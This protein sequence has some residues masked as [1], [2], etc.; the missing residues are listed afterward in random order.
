MRV[1][2]HILKNRNNQYADELDMSL[3]R[4]DAPNLSQSDAEFV[5]SVDNNT[6]TIIVENRKQ[7]FS[8]TQGY[9]EI[10]YVVSEST[11]DYV[12]RQTMSQFDASVVIT[13]DNVEYTAQD[14]ANPVAIDTDASITYLKKSC[15]CKDNHYTSWNSS[16]GAEPADADR[17][18]YLVW[19]IR[20]EISATQPYDFALTDVF[21]YPDASIVGYKL[22]GESVYSQNRTL[23]NQRKTGYRTDY[24]LTRHKKSSYDPLDYYT[25]ENKVKATVTPVDS[26]NA[27]YKT[28]SD[29]YTYRH[30]EYHFPTG[31]LYS[32]KFGNN[33]WYEY[34][35]K[36]WDI[37]SYKLNEFQRYDP[38]IYSN[39]ELEDSLYYAVT[40]YGYQYPWTLRR[41]GDRSDPNDL[42]VEKVSY[43]IEDYKLYLN[44]TIGYDGEIINADSWANARQLTPDDYYLHN[45]N[46]WLTVRDV[47]FNNVTNSF[48]NADYTAYTA[49]DVLIFEGRYGDEWVQLAH[50]SY[51]TSI[52]S[53]TVLAPDLVEYSNGRFYMKTKTCTGYR[54][55]TANSHY[56]TKVTVE[57][58]FRLKSSVYTYNQS[59]NKNKIW[60]TNIS[61]SEIRDWSDS[62]LFTKN[63]IAE[64]YV[65]ADE[66]H[67]SIK[68]TTTKNR[69][70]DTE[71]REVG[72]EWSITLKETTPTST[73]EDYIRQNGGT[74][75][76]LLPYGTSVDLDTLKV[77]LDGKKYDKWTLDTEIL[78]NYKGSG[79][80]MLIIRITQSFNT[81]TIYLT[82]ITSWN[83][84]MEENYVL[85]NEVAYETGN[86]SIGDGYPDV[87]PSDKLPSP[88]L[89]TDLDP[90]S[91]A[92]RFIYS[93]YQTEH[94]IVTSI[95]SG[96]NKLVSAL[97]D[98]RF[99][100]DTTVHPD[101]GYVYKLNYTTNSVTRTKDIILFDS[102]E[103]YTNE[104]DW[105]G[106]L[107]A[108][109][110]SQPQ[111][112]GAAPVVYYSSIGNLSLSDHHDLEEVSG[113]EPVWVRAEDFGDI[114]QA[115]AV[116]IDL[117]HTEG[118]GDFVLDNSSSLTVY[119]YMKAPSTVQSEKIDPVALNNV[120]I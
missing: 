52:N 5:Y 20:S 25:L 65:V 51:N 84:L 48:D 113:G 46:F 9:F 77:Y 86:S 6:N 109:D 45:L 62:L 44:Q 67:S 53:C 106:S 39:R 42:G 80:T 31:H 10:G 55:S 72:T 12:D 35:Y 92:E 15:V 85:N 89:M 91:N 104:S 98:A 75:Y 14:S 36:H 76:D 7:L 41:D 8:G 71:R 69:F 19:S 29:T 3:P 24:L 116:A 60:I 63:D 114:S 58:D 17:Y 90:E 103:N 21:D 112:L 23:Q 54:V 79:R 101:E 96:L 73:G 2:L 87:P 11:M 47:V 27:S 88:E 34:E 99:S 32:R 18:N 68:K 38:A 57:P 93:W 102:L 26:N 82:T 100:R 49:D 105:R 16:W 95:S 97:E 66:R 30:Y 78:L 40:A 107:T 61:H 83:T 28:S 37:A 43:V 119:L 108:V 74:V 111:R 50:Y 117:R 33:N 81:A 115:K 22:D 56:Y 120:Y 4:S 118:G 1:P 59:I 110:V 70:N 94:Q 64:D 13:K